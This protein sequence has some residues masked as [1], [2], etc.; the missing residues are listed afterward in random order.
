MPSEGHVELHCLCVVAH[1]HCL[2]ICWNVFPTNPN[3]ASLGNGEWNCLSV[4]GHVTGDEKY[5]CVIWNEFMRFSR[6]AF[7]SVYCANFR[8]LF[9]GVLYIYLWYRHA[10]SVSNG[11]VGGSRLCGLFSVES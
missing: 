6:I 7:G 10:T 9:L 4:V 8:G 1:T 5:D 2:S 11:C 3:I